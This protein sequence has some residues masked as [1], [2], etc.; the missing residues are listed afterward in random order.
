MVG[1]VL[2]TILG[3]F[4][5]IARLSKNWVLS[6]LAAAYVEVLRDIPV[7][8]QLLFWY[9][10][11]QTLPSVRDAFSPDPRRLLLESRPEGSPVRLGAGA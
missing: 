11:M 7:L 2:T 4:I 6:R 3:T 1:I 8:L 9:M 10:L 5:G